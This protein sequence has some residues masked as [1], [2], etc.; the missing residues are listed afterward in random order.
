MFPCGSTGRGINAEAALTQSDN[1]LK[2]KD[3]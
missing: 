2:I 3:V 1:E